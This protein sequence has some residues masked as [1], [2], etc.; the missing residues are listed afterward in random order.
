MIQVC[1]LPFVFFS[2]P[3]LMPILA[4]TLVAACYGCE[5][6]KGLVQQEINI[7]MLLSLLRSCRNV[8]PVLRSN[9]NTDNNGPVDD[10]SECNHLSLDFKK[11]QVDIPLRSTRQNTRNTRLSFGRGCASG[12]STKI[13]KLRNQRDSKATKSCEEVALKH[14]LPAPETS[15]MMLHCRFPLSFIDRAENFFS[16]GIPSMADKV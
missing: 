8:L 15:S 2:D 6:N 16:T 5:Q 3:E 7:D 14:N 10:S 9:S 1:D 11:A 4:G 12:S 13:G